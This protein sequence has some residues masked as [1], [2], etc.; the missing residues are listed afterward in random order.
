MNNKHPDSMHHALCAYAHRLTGG[1]PLLADKLLAATLTRLAESATAY[2][3]TL[4]DLTTWAK[5]VMQN[6]FRQT[7]KDADL[8]ELHHLAYRGTLNPMQPCSNKEYSLKEQILMMS[9]LTPQQAAAATL[10][11]GGYT[12]KAIAHAMN[13]TTAQAKDHLGKARYVLGHVWDS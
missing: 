1:N 3:P 9:R 8:H 6:T 10:R 4:I 5:M 2:P 13:I 12:H 7:T 11:L